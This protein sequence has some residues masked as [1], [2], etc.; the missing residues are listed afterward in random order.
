MLSNLI[1]SFVEGGKHCVNLPT[2]AYEK[3]RTGHNLI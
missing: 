1:P 3:G 2:S